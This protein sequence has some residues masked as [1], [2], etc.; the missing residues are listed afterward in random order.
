MVRKGIALPPPEKLWKVLLRDEMQVIDATALRILREVGIWVET[1]EMLKRAGEMGCDVDHAKRIV[2]F[3]E[4]VV[5]EFVGKAPR[6]Y[7]IFAR[8]PKND[9]LIEGPGKKSYLL[10]GGAAP[11]RCYWDENTKQY[12]FKD[13]TIDDTFYMLKVLEALDNVDEVY[14]PCLDTKSA[15]AGLPGAIHESYALLT[16]CTK[17]VNATGASPQVSEEWDFHARLAAEAVGG[18]E[19]LR[20][21]P[22][23]S[24]HVSEAGPLQ[25]P[26]AAAY[27]IIGATK[28]GFPCQHLAT[29]ASAPAAAPMTL[30]GG[31]ALFEAGVLSLLAIVQAYRAGHPCVPC[32]MAPSISLKTGVLLVGAPDSYI[33]TV[34]MCQI[35]H[36]IYGLPAM[37]VPKGCSAMVPD[38][39]AAY[40][41]AICTAFNIQSGHDVLQYS[42]A[43]AGG[44]ADMAV[45]R[46]E[47][48]GYMK[49]AM[50]R[51]DD[52]IPTPEN[53]AFDVIKE[54]GPQGTFFKHPHTLRHLGLQY[55][56]KVADYNTLT[57]WQQKGRVSMMDNVRKRVK[58][59]EKFEVPKLPADVDERMR[60]IVSEADEKMKR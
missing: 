11:M 5:K 38:A 45:L 17:H 46:D 34:G 42:P 4:T 25:L 24:A 32:T 60:A 6:N 50:G 26:K 44:S 3:P 58:E 59:L 14:T 57:A 10:L 33:S 2:K 49:N 29:F 13:S 36:E 20:K 56:P 23:M 12:E 19:E 16:G 43:G 28:Y 35:W 37:T 53:L 41:A 31:L 8:D 1:D 54:A 47:L 55:V 9:I 48:V 39:Q 15:R 52:M 18:M 40:E 21:R 51:L 30:A 7:T 22:I 27:N